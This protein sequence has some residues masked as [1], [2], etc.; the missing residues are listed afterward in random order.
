MTRAAIYARYSCDRQSEA[1]CEDQIRECRRFAE[2]KGWT[3]AE[4]VVVAEEGIS[5]ASRHNR[6]GLLALVADA[7]R[8]FDML[9]VF[10]VSR[11]GRNDEDVA[12]VRNRLAD[13]GARCVE[14]ANGEALDSL[15][16]R[17]RGILAGEQRE[18]IGQ[19]TRR[20]LRGQF[21]RGYAPGAAPF[22]YRLEADPEARDAARKCK[23]LVIHEAEAA[24]VRRIFADYSKGTGAKILARR[25]NAEGAPV[26]VP[27]ASKVRPSWSPTSLHA[28]LENPIYRGE[29]VW[30]RS[31]WTKVHATGRRRRSEVPAAEWVRREAPELAIVS[32][33]LWQ[34]AQD[35]RVRQRRGARIGSHGRIVPRGGR[36]SAR[37][38]LSGLVVCD[39]CGGGFGAQ[40]R[41]RWG[42]NAAHQ[43]GVCDA[44]QLVGQLDLEGAV[45]RGLAELLDADALSA[46]AKLAE[47]EVSRVL[48]DREAPSRVEAELARVE[49]KAARLVDLAADGDLG[50]EAA[51]AKLTALEAERRGLRER[52]TTAR[53]KAPA[54]GA[55]ADAIR[56]ALA[57]VAGLLHGDT[58][59]ARDALRA[60]L[61]GEPLRAVADG[62]GYRLEGALEV[63][64]GGPKARPPVAVGSGGRIRTCD[65]RVMSPPSYQTAPPRSET[66][67]R[68]GAAFARVKPALVHEGCREKR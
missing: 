61:G 31:R 38:L 20:G 53:S 21:E 63:Q 27:R 3:V 9:V 65:L 52:L 45:E 23:R 15:S 28:L 41:G 1:S 49:A 17:V 22:G 51:R 14:A 6:P 5:G 34:A 25:L 60:L 59:G 46:V 2:A 4:G 44:R 58:E 26:P 19:N 40:H 37:Y 55:V 62:A 11:V 33:E 66:A 35:A 50:A 8:A 68:I 36:P 29:L 43:R 12:W 16:S 47:A 67:R 39:L 57:D 10:D 24:I 42:C 7:G 64:T 48:S 30:G 18:A 56:R 13:S 54:P 32:A